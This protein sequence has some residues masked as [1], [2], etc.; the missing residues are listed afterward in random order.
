MAVV[1]S[2]SLYGPSL[3]ASADGAA[4]FEGLL[5]G[6][7]TLPKVLSGVGQRLVACLPSRSTLR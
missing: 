3:A 4:S 5:Q 6:L 7:T 1:P 2:G